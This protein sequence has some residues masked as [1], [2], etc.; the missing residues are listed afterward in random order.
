MWEI[1]KNEARKMVIASRMPE[2]RKCQ[3]LEQLS[4]ENKW[5]EINSSK[6]S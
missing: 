6:C 5:V 2:K 4:L 1:L 3:L